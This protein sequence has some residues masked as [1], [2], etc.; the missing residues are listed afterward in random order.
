MPYVQKLGESEIEEQFYQWA[1]VMH[2]PNIDGY[3]GWGC[4]QKLYKFKFMLDQMIES[5]PRYH[6]EDEWLLDRRIKLAEKKL[7]GR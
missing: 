4:K 7:S 1:D 6:G 3:N 5:A 2:D